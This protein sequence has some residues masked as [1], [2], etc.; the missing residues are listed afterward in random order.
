MSAS[1]GPSFLTMIGIQIVLS[2]GHTS[3]G[4]RNDSLKSAGVI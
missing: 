1:A 4:I 3:R 2:R